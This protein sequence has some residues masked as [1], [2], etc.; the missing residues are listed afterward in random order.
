MTEMYVSGTT[1]LYGNGNGEVVI[2]TNEGKVITFYA[3]E[4]FKDL[5]SIISLTQQE[6]SAEDELIKESWVTLGKKL[7][8]QYKRPVGRPKKRASDDVLEQLLNS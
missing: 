3:R 8:K 7:T 1:T 6:V 4:L 2:E 5:P